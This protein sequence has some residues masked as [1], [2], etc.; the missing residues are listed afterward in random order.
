MHLVY[1]DD[2]RDEQLCVFSGL[3][4]SAEHWRTCFDQLKDFR[5]ELKV[6]DGIFVRKELH[7]WK[8]VSGRG[9]ISN[10]VV[11]K[12]RRSEIF[13]SA[14][15]L[16]A[17]MPEAKVIN[18]VSTADD[19]ER[20][21]E[22][23]AN[24]IQRTV[25]AWGSHAMLV[26]DEGKEASYTRLIRKMGVYNPIPS[27]LGYWP[28]G[29]STRNITVDRILEDPVFKT[30]GGRTSFNSPTSALTHYCARSG[31]SRPR[32]STGWTRRSICSIQ[33]CSVKQR[34]TTRRG[35]CDPCQANP[36]GAGPTLTSVGELGPALHSVSPS[37]DGP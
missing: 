17:E 20:L 11:T 21:F 27:R 28:E 30:R 16:A 26:C 5:R 2:S 18:G 15:R 24:R 19:D 9:R 10:Q 32:P 33:S 25:A 1:L 8:L 13:K 31:R 12:Y 4:I 7:A 3:I 29:T 23:I 22:G 35:S 6:S 37:S 14:L 34:A 36:L